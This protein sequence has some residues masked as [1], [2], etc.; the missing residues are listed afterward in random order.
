[1]VVEEEHEQMEIDL[2]EN[3]ISEIPALLYR[4][5]DTVDLELL[6]VDHISVWCINDSSIESRCMVDPYTA[7][8]VLDT[9]M[10]ES[11][12]KSVVLDI[13]EDDFIVQFIESNY[14]EM[15]PDEENEVD[16][17]DESEEDADSETGENKE[18]EENK[19]CFGC[20]MHN[21]ED[22]ECFGD[23]SFLKYA[24]ATLIS[25]KDA[26][27]QRSLELS[28]VLGRMGVDVTEGILTLVLSMIPIAAMS[29]LGL[30]EISKLVFVI[31][32]HLNVSIVEGNFN[33]TNVN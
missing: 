8:T 5:T 25:K 27:E 12:P 2:M 33:T 30:V 26:I 24:M 7:R 19:N 15:Y 9:R 14:L 16:E 23:S 3:N 17:N 10:V 20:I 22:N 4:I 6:M 32:K 1:V 11:L 29:N 18:D 28:R 21:V 31:S 13:S